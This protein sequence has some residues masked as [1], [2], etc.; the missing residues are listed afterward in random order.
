MKQKVGVFWVVLA[1]FLSLMVTLLPEEAQAV[2]SFARQI[3]KPCSACHTIWPNLNQAGRQFKVKAYTDVS[4]EWKLIKKD[5][6]DLLTV[7]PVSLRVI[8]YP[9]YTEKR[10]DGVTASNTTDYTNIPEAIEMFFSSRI[11]E[12]LGF[13]SEVA[14]VPTENKDAELQIAKLAFQHP[15]GKGDTLGL[16]LFKGVAVSADPFNS[17]G[18]RDRTMIYDRKAGI[19]AQGFDFKMLDDNQAL[20]AHGY[21]LGNRLYGAIGAMR[22][23]GNTGGTV[24]D[25]ID[26]YFRLAWDQKLPDG[27]VTF[28]AAHY[29]GKQRVVTY[30]SKV[31]RTYVDV[32]LEQNFGEDHLLEIQALYGTGDEEN[33]D[34]ANLKKE[35][36]GFYLEGDYFFQKKIGVIAAYDLVNYKKH[37]VDKERTWVIGA[38]YIPWPNVKVALQFENVR[39]DPTTGPIE[40]EKVLRTVVDIAF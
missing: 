10:A 1:V 21:F 18:G 20:V 22:G 3:Q 26:G 38:R 6:L 25:P 32:S 11:N 9:Y 7:L 2:P 17:F 4:P 12:N 27:A 13:F 40:T 31:K 8:S 29:T 37:T 36:N 24:A 34:G 19:L 33:V 30:D 5:G 14:W 28:G 15:I 35:L 23:K 39:T 16:V